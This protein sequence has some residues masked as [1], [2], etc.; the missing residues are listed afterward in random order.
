MKK[1]FT[2]TGVSLISFFVLSSF[3]EAQ[4]N[5]TNAVQGIG[6]FA[7]LINAFTQTVVK[8]T[9]TLFMALAMVAFLYGIVQYIW[10]GRGGD[11]TKIGK[12]NTFIKWSLVALFVMFSVYGIIKFAQ[13]FICGG[14]ECDNTITI[15]DINFGGKSSNSGTTNGTGG[16]APGGAVNPLGTGGVV[17]PVTGATGNPAFDACIAAGGG[18]SECRTIT[19]ATG[20]GTTVTCASITDRAVCTGRSCTWSEDEGTCR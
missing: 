11:S 13:T 16:A 17:T 7:G 18:V 4:A 20:G 2:A 1:I 6:T 3:V 15:P 19:G 8:A 9:G 14:K 12:G 5:A 10:G